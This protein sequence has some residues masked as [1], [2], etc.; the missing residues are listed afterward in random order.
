[1]TKF[2]NGNIIIDLDWGRVFIDDEFVLVSMRE[3]QVLLTFMR[4]VGKRVPYEDFDDL[5]GISSGTLRVTI[6]RLLK[7]IGNDII[8]AGNKREPGYVMPYA[9]IGEEN[10]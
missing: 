2:I 1:M 8:M 6:S 4:N 10:E 3:Y 5:F 7:K 9:S